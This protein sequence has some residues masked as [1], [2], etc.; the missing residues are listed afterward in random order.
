MN[1]LLNNL[2]TTKIQT[3]PKLRKEYEKKE[4]L[5]EKKKDFFEDDQY[6]L[7]PIRKHSSVQFN[8]FIQKQF[9]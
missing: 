5:F 2:K 7:K 4:N 1:Q 6:T 9:F 8:L 3:D